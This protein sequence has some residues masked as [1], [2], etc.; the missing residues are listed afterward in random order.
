MLKERLLSLLPND[1]DDPEKRYFKTVIYLSMGLILLM[2]IS[3][4]IAFLLTLKRAEQTMVPDLTG[5]EL[6]NALVELQNRELVPWV[7]LKYS[8]DLNDKGTVLSQSPQRGSI[9]R[10]K[11]II[12]MVVSRGSVIDEVDDYT[13]WNLSDLE[14]HLKSLVSIYG[15]LLTISDTIQYVFDEAPAGTILEQ[16]PSPGTDISE[17]TQIHLVVSSGPQ[18]EQIVVPE[19]TEMNYWDA[20]HEL[21]TEGIFF[22]VNARPKRGEEESGTVVNQT[23]VP[24]TKVPADTIFQLTIA[25][26]ESVDE[27]LVFGVLEKRLPNYNIPARIKVEAIS[28]AGERRTVYSFLHPGGLFSVPYFEKMGTTIVISIEGVEKFTHLVEKE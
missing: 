11:S 24:G 18:G 22:I 19:L 13:G 6:E 7:Q 26:G 5:M 9:V 23:P 14:I 3:G 21:S 1:N 17:P 2:L 8:Q 25:N 20:I 16:A 10:A 12:S 27:D 28:P 4:S 15:P